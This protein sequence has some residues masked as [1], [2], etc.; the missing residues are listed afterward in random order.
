MKSSCEY[1]LPLPYSFLSLLPQ[2]LCNQ[3]LYEC[4]LD[5]GLFIFCLC[6]KDEAIPSSPVL[7]K[8][9]DAEVETGTWKTTEKA[10]ITPDPPAANQAMKGIFIKYQIM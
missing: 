10:E 3:I 9:K 4:I 5:R 1:K 6:S 7:P 8:S 2:L